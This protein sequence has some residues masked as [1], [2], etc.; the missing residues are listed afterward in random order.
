ME[1]LKERVIRHEGK[2]LK[3][4][5]CSAGKLTIGVGHNYEDNPLPPDIASYLDKNGCITEMM[6]AH[7]FDVDIG[8]AVRT[9]DRNFPWA[10]KLDNVRYDVLVEMCF[11]LGIGTLKQFKKMLACLEA[12]D[13]DGAAQNMLNSAWHRQTPGR[14]E[15][16][17]ALML[18]GSTN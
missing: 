9:V 6:S 1:T 3:P 14:C 2:R 8:N 16:L 11:Q 10:Q 13:I 17:A 4:Y 7:L 12:G 18:K 5:R 15:E